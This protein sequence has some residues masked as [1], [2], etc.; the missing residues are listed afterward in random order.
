MS[1]SK[2]LRLG[3]GYSIEDRH[4]V[5]AHYSLFGT[6]HLGELSV[7]AQAGCHIREFL[8]GHSLF[9]MRDRDY[10]YQ[11]CDAIDLPQ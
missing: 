4:T 3:R 6:S 11:I 1:L 7:P 8:D 2:Q 5:N 9:N 10:F